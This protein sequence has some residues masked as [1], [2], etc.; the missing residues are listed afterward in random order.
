M[1]E[2]K[3][4][5]GASRG[6]FD[7]LNSTY[8]QIIYLDPNHP[9]NS[10]DTLNGFSKGAQTVES[11]DKTYVLIA[12][13]TRMLTNGYFDP[14]RVKRIEY[15]RRGPHDFGNQYSEFILIIKPTEYNFTNDKK[16]REDLRF[17]EWIG[18][19]YR[20]IQCGKLNYGELD[21]QPV[22]IEEKDLFSLSRGRFSTQEKLNQHCRLLE[23]LG[24][25]RDMIHNFYVKYR[26]QYLS[27]SPEQLIQLVD[28]FKSV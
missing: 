12:M 11:A 9:K 26:E 23:S 1:S 7:P 13:I 3:K 14:T 21:I 24:Y 6:Q 5:P 2:K 8:K 25:P 20:Q 18:K 10:C 15:Y 28:K 17:N 16:L 4:F 27:T 22:K 19:L